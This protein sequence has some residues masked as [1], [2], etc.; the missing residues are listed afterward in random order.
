M[1]FPSQKAVPFWCEH[2]IHQDGPSE[3]RGLATPREAFLPDGPHWDQFPPLS[4]S[5]L[6]HPDRTLL[7]SYEPKAA[8]KATIASLV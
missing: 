5:L 6:P 1:V 3:D 4:L 2:G 7:P 8:E